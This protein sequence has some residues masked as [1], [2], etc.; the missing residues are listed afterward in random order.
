MPAYTFVS[1]HRG[2]SASIRTAPSA[3]TIWRAKQRPWAGIRNRFGSSIGISVSPA[4]E[5]PIARTS[6]WHLP[7]TRPFNHL[8]GAAEQRGRNSHAE[9]LGGFDIDDQLDC[10]GLLH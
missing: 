10:G 6:R 3:N 8:I 2:K 9:H 7:L 4:P 5:R 1:R